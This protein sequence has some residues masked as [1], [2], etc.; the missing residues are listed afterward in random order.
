MAIT[1]ES[2]ITTKQTETHEKYMLYSVVERNKVHF[3]K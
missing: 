2:V 3:L 1:L